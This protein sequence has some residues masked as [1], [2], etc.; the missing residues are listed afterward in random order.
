MQ[1]LGEIM[2]RYGTLK[3]AASLAG[4]DSNKIEQQC[5]TSE[6][7][8]KGTFK[9]MFFKVRLISMIS[10]FFFANTFLLIF[11]AVFFRS[12]LYLISILLSLAIGMG[13]F[14]L[15]HRQFLKIDYETIILL[16]EAKKTFDIYFDRYKKRTINSL[17]LFVGLSAFFVS[18]TFERSPL[19]NMNHDELSALF[20]LNMNIILL[21]LSIC[22]KNVI[23]LLYLGK[24]ADRQMR[25]S[26]QK[27]IGKA[28]VIC[29]VFL[30]IS[31]VGTYILNRFLY[32]PFIILYI[33][34]AIFIVV[35]FGINYK[36]RAKLVIKN[37]RINK[38]R[39]AVF[40]MAA[41]VLFTIE[42]MKTDFWVL[43]P[44]ISGVSSIEHTEHEISYDDKTGVYTI[45]A[46][47]NDFKILHLTDIHLGGS[48]NSVYKD[49]K[50]LEAC[51]K[52]IT[53]TKPDF[54]IVTGDLVFPMGIMSRLFNNQ[55]PVI[56]FANF[57]RNIGIPWAF[58][59]GNHDTETMATGDR[60]EIQELYESLSL[61]PSK[62][63][64]YPH[65][66]PKILTG[67]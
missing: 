28:T 45:A 63:L 52:L 44:Y 12:P 8:N 53:Y 31:L 62:N 65:T 40:F 7:I 24:A 58:T 22:F 3:T 35:F 5:Q 59:Y 55:A 43:Q 33:L 27:Y 26:V 25:I 16:P 9:R 4:A 42:Y 20:I 60:K 54:V 49:Y 51:R 57:M 47:E 50:A 41:V 30:F 61:Q 48:A 56:Q 32:N 39:F 1:A 14:W 2:S 37:L 21:G 34:T 64:L 11:Q 36:T 66:Q 23:Y 10:A 29:I 67:A 17:L 13:F 6:E 18:R 19:S 15:C 46:G 38:L